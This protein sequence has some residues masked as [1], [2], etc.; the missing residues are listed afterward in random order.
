[1]RK[2]HKFSDKLG[3]MGSQKVAKITDNMAKIPDSTVH[4]VDKCKM[5]LPYWGPGR[6]YY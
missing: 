3:E 6:R 5:I 2:N 1:M 4:N